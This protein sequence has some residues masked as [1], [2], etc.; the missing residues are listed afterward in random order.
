MGGASCYSNAAPSLPVA[1]RAFQSCRHLVMFARSFL[2]DSVLSIHDIR[3][4]SLSGTKNDDRR[5]RMVSKF[6]ELDVICSDGR[7]A[8]S[9]SSK[10]FIH[11]NK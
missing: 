1:I 9:I 11:F 5:D 7:M 3:A 2:S 4:S 8:I 10:I 6:A